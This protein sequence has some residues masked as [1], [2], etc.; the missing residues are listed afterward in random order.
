MSH[1]EI[2][3]PH[4]TSL[5]ERR[6]FGMFHVSVCLNKGMLQGEKDYCFMALTRLCGPLQVA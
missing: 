1:P 6:K 3:G 2:F 4:A 5:G